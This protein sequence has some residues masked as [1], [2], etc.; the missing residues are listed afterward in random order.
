[1]AEPKKEEV[2]VVKIPETKLEPLKEIPA[3]PSPEKVHVELFLHSTG[4]PLWERGG[5]RA[6]AKSKGKEFATDKEFE[7]LF[8]SY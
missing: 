4:C 2:K 7:E 3:S 1:M 8:K 6:F 5:K